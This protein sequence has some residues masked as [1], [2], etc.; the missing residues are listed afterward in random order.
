[1]MLRSETLHV[2]CCR[3]FLCNSLDS[4]N[5]QWEL[6]NKFYNGLFAQQL[7]FPFVRFIHCF[8]SFALESNRIKYLL[9]SSG[10][11]VEEFSQLL[12]NDYDNEA[13]WISVSGNYLSTMFA[14]HLGT[15][16]RGGFESWKRWNKDHRNV[17]CKQRIFCRQIR[18]FLNVMVQLQILVTSHSFHVE[19]GISTSSA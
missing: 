14:I 4:S 16:F 7:F 9:F 10:M 3:Y 8:A 13:R 12:K 6:I 18:W 2:D 1:M 17:N 19:K 15:V 11:F 5:T